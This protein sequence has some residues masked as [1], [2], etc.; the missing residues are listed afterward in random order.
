M[1]NKIS[2]FIQVG[3]NHQENIIINSAIINTSMKRIEKDFNEGNI[4]QAMEDLSSLMD[5]NKD[6]KKTRYQLL[7]KK[8]SFCFSLYRYNEAIKLLENTAANYI[9]FL[10]V[11]FEEIRLIQLSLE[12]NEKDFFLLTDK[13][14]A[15]SRKIL[16]RKKFELMYYLNSSDLHKAKEIFE[17][18]D[19]EIQKSKEYALMG[20]HIYSSFSDYENTNLFYQIALSHDISF[21]DK[22]K[23]PRTVKIT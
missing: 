15:E 8:S 1:I 7:I 23:P 16:N 12:K 20:G 2:S 11:S 5:E 18:L 22:L 4:N 13:I 3:N 14:I 17:S 21:L 6:N 9:D 10:D 19:E